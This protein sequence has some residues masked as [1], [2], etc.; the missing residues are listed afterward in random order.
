M[1]YR[2]K[3]VVIEAHRWE[4][5]ENGRNKNPW[6]RSHLQ[7]LKFPVSA[8]SLNLLIPTLEGEMMANPGD[9][10]I[11]GVHGEFYPCKPEIFAKTYEPLEDEAGK[12]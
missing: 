4:P 5:T 1:K 3:P 2:K 11:K 7:A 9:W 12:V 8:V 6:P 10:I